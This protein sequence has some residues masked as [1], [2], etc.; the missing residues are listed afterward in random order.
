M[1]CWHDELENASSEAEIMKS[2][3]DYLRL[4]VPR[5]LSPMAIGLEDLKI[6]SSDDIETV[7]R[8]LADT[9]AYIEA[10]SRDGAHMRELTEYFWRA[11]ARI[12]E[13]RSARA[14]GRSELRSLR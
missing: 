3:T 7:K 9:P 4:W 11:S 14:R 8:K 10:G 13:L 6:R 5:R 12:G 1:D 2:A